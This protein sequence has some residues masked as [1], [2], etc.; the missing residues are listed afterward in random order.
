MDASTSSC[1]E[2][3]ATTS[4][5]RS[6]AAARR[7]RLRLLALVVAVEL[8][9]DVVE[10]RVR[11]LGS[12]RA[13]RA[14]LL[15]G[16]RLA[17]IRSAVAVAGPRHLAVRLDPARSRSRGGPALLRAVAPAR[18]A[19]PGSTPRFCERLS[20]VDLGHRL[21]LGDQGKRRW[22]LRQCGA[23][24]L[25]VVVGGVVAGATRVASHHRDG[26]GL[27][28]WRDG[29]GRRLVR[30]H[31]RRVASGSCAGRARAASVRAPAARLGS[32]ARRRGS[33][34]LLGVGGDGARAP[35]SRRLGG[36]TLTLVLRICLERV[37]RSHV[38]EE[39]ASG[40]TVRVL[41]VLLESLRAR[42]LGGASR[43][44]RETAAVEL[45]VTRRRWRWCGI[46][47]N[48]ARCCEG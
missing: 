11:E 10:A 36:A 8:E 1:A 23:E 26:D 19:P 38:R 43:P 5:R 45:V 30:P 14:L 7:E 29:Y 44:R 32:A 12:A 15:L 20:D 27:R 3:G 16:L 34:I 37:A 18:A 28:A 33:H 22:S 40:R 25:V 46:G 13:E 31:Q 6:E 24:L 41:V 42:R 4:S 39:K 48:R 2:A 47:R 9:I 35:V 21:I 17:T